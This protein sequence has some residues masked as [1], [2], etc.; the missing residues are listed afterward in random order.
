MGNIWNKLNKL[1]KSNYEIAKE[2]NIPEDKVEEIM[3]GK[4]Q[5]PTDRIDKFIEVLKKDDK[6]QKQLD[7]IEARQWY[8]KT[9][10][11]Q[12]RIE[13]GYR[14]QRSL[15]EVLKLDVSVINRLETRSALDKHHV[16]DTTFIR[17]CDFMRDD[18]N[19][20]INS[21]KINN[22]KTN[23]KKTKSGETLKLRY[24]IPEKERQEILNTD[25]E[26]VLEWYKN[27]DLR[28]WIEQRGWSH[29]DLAKALNY[30]SSSSITDMLNNKPKNG[31][32][33]LKNYQI[34]LTR[35]YLY[36]KKQ[37]EEVHNKIDVIDT[38]DEDIEVLDEEPIKTEEE[39]L[40]DYNQ[41]KYE[42]A[43][44]DTYNTSQELLAE[45]QIEAE[46]VYKMLNKAEEEKQE[47]EDANERFIKG[48]ELKNN[49]IMRLEYELEEARK[50]IARYEK[51][52]DM[53]IV[54]K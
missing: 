17:Y 16:S 41:K 24:N 46:K 4:R 28:E 44:K 25:W 53:I 26:E 15:A 5:V 38:S 48:H 22:K 27:F 31:K 42:E 10:L 6:V 40:V 8:D 7:L 13:M 18:L 37:E 19:K 20:I 49:K 34:V 11:K 30:K 2:T 50:Q 9:N 52:I 12:R 21:K 32:K 1:N 36:I 23:N 54:E 14:T 43:L 35:V 51:L 45:Q 33:D 29:G 3:K 47:L 39:L